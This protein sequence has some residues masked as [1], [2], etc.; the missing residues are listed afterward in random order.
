[1]IHF[2]HEAMNMGC[3]CAH[4]MCRM[5]VELGEVIACPTCRKRRSSPTKDRKWLSTYMEWYGH[6]T[7]ACPGCK[8]EI[9]PSRLKAHERSC[10]SYRDH[11]DQM[12][13]DDRT[14]YRSRAN[15]VEKD[16]QELENKIQLQNNLID[17]L[18]DECDELEAMADRAEIERKWYQ[19]ESVELTKKINKA[20]RP[21]ETLGKKLAEVTQKL[22]VIREDVLTSRRAHCDYH[23]NKRM[24][25]PPIPPLSVAQGQEGEAPPRPYPYHSPL[26]ESEAY[27]GVASGS[28]GN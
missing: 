16:N 18:E 24:R 22:T 9:A 10:P 20:L 26:A 14:H 25:L 3:S 19:T 5:C 15:R 21:L 11:V 13:K 7:V 27:S 12:I 2:R 8:K 17:E 6:K 23:Q 4:H 28:E 1:M